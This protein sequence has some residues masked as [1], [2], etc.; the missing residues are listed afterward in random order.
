M[1]IAILC[2]NSVVKLFCEVSV[3]FVYEQGVFDFGLIEAFNLN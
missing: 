2:T 1:P 3:L